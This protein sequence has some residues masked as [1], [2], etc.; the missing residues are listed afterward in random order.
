MYNFQNWEK[1]AADLGN[2]RSG[3]AVCVHYYTTLSDKIRKDKFD[4]E[5]DQFLVDVV[6]ACRIGNYIPWSKVSHYFQNRSRSQLYHRYKYNLKY[7]H[8][9]KGSFSQAED[10]LVVLLV[11]KFGKDFTRCSKFIPH[12]TP[13]QIAHRY[14]NYLMFDEIKLGCWTL[15][16]DVVILDH[17]KVYGEKN[18]SKLFSTLKTKNRSHLRQR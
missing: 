6:D 11:R 7:S 9:K 3:F 2:N 15:E 5:E 18:W 12:R 10:V 16:D 14:K 17:V 1:I 13:P 4:A 8:M